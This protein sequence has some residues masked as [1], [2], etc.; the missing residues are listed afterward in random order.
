MKQIYRKPWF[1]ILPI[2]VLIIFLLVDV[3]RLFTPSG[4]AAGTGFSTYH[5][6]YY[7][8]TINY[9]S[10][11]KMIHN[12]VHT[13]EFAA[14]GSPA[15]CQISINVTREAMIPQKALLSVVPRGAYSV[16]HSTIDGSPAIVFSQYSSSVQGPDGKFTS[17]ST[18]K[19]VVGQGNTAHGVNLYSLALDM[20]RAAYL[21]S[22]NVEPHTACESDFE[23]MTNSLVLSKGTNVD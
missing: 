19:V 5:D 11:W 8:Y 21:R 2:V 12:P 4:S 9:P 3:L 14:P 6:S 10:T 16:S 13:T 18:K 17:A 15:T 22:K 23:V 7:G 20:Y 1:R